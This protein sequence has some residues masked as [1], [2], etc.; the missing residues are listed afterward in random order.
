MYCPNYIEFERSCQLKLGNITL[1]TT[2]FCATSRFKEC[3]FYKTLN[4]I[5]YTCYY[6]KNAPAFDHFP[7]VDFEKFV[8]M[9]N[10]YCLSKKNNKNCARYK[11]RKKGDH[12]PSNLL[13]DGSFF[14]KNNGRK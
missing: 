8:E 4:N 12:P 13:P 5:G 7:A 11:L 10:K 9:A 1:D 3:P 14:K 2:F 6:L